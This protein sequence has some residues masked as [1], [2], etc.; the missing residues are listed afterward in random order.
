[1]SSR[2]LRP[3]EVARRAGIGRDSLSLYMN[4]KTLPTAVSL[5]KIADALGISAEELMPGTGERGPDRLIAPEFE[6]TALSNNAE[7]SWLRI[8]KLVSTGCAMQVIQLLI[9]DERA[10]KEASDLANPLP[11]AR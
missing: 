9:E 10:R 3:S 5:R 7:L 4:A 8:N 2:E 1:M 6:M 11:Q